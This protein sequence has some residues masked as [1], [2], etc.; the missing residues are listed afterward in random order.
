MPEQYATSIVLHLAF[1]PLHYTEQWSLSYYSFLSYIFIHTT[2]L[3][4]IVNMAMLASFGKILLY[5]A[6]E[7]LFWL[8]SVMSVI[9]GALGHYILYPTVPLVGSSSLV[10]GFIGAIA[11]LG[12]YRFW[13]P[14]PLNNPKTR[15][16]LIIIFV[17]FNVITTILPAQAFGFGYHE[18]VSWSAHIGGFFMACMS[19]ILYAK[20]KN[21]KYIC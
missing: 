3:H 21:Y 11:I 10:S 2:W 8:I 16:G 18:A 9:G 20:I 12:Y 4:L 17:I 6:G 15:H 7:K 1:I 13:L 14:A 5:S 19:V